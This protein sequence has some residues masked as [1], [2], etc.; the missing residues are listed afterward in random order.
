MIFLLSTPSLAKNQNI[1]SALTSKGSP[2]QDTYLLEQGQG[3]LLAVEDDGEGTAFKSIMRIVHKTLKSDG[4]DHFLVP[5][6]ASDEYYKKVSPKAKRWIAKYDIT[7]QDDE[8]DVSIPDFDELI[9]L[10]TQKQK[11]DDLFAGEILKDA[12]ASLGRVVE[13]ASSNLLLCGSPGTGKGS[14]AMAAV[15]LAQRRT[16]KTSLYLNA[17]LLEGLPPY[18]VLETINNLLPQAEGGILIIRRLDVLA[19][20]TNELGAD[21]MKLIINRAN[22]YPAAIKIVATA[23]GSDLATFAKS[24]AEFSRAFPAQISFPDFPMQTLTSIFNQK[25]A[26]AQIKAGP[27]VMARAQ[28]YL[29]RAKK[30]RK[31]RFTNAIEVN[32]LISKSIDRMAVRLVQEGRDFR[33]TS[34]KQKIKPEQLEAMSSFTAGDIPLY[35]HENESPVRA[36]TGPKVH[37]LYRMP[38]VP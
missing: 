32:D 10:E 34:E 19:K 4:A 33:P 36:H 11:L 25:M 27:G 23:V 21:P 26:R 8:R 37:P 6:Y 24:D 17:K 28:A 30:E 15:A 22:T 29:E 9:G 7:S 5:F 18:N 38:I 3:F 16:G 31:Y 35:G 20:I 1:V 13:P 2:V 12:M 14:F